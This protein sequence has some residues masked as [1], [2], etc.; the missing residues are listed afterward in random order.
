MSSESVA[1][2]KKATFASLLERYK[3]SFVSRIPKF[4]NPERLFQVARGSILSN[5]DLLACE[6]MGVLLCVSQILQ[7]GLEPNGPTE[8]AYVLP[9]W[10]SKRQQHEASMVISYKGYIDLALRSESCVD[11]ESQ[12]VYEKDR[13]SFRRT[14]DGPK[15]DHEP[16]LD[17]EP[18]DKR[19]VY[20]VAWREKGGKVYPHFEIVTRREILAIKERFAP[21]NRQGKLVGPWVTDEAEMWRKT[22]IR[23]LTKYLQL[24]PDLQLASAIDGAHVVATVN[25]IDQALAGSSRLVPDGEEEESKV[26]PVVVSSESKAESPAVVTPIS[27]AAAQ[28]AEAKAAPKAE[29]SAAHQSRPAAAETSVPSATEKAATPARSATAATAP[30]AATAPSAAAPAATKTATPTTAAS[31]KESSQNSTPPAAAS[32]AEKPAPAI[33]DPFEELH[34]FLGE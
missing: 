30:A 9:R 32:A 6:P 17:D 19:L 3:D 2:P 20:A 16:F 26:A 13:F 29:M 5:S 8:Q 14:Q 10:N 28:K 7:L 23:R 15:L 22:A 24:S 1:N 25:D 27:E 12:I 33:A 31:Q 34:M 18:G 11:I 21:T 4:A